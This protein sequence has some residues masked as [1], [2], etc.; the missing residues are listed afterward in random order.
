M[1]RDLRTCCLRELAFQIISTQY[2][3]PH[4]HHQSDQNDDE[5]FNDEYDDVED[6]FGQDLKGKAAYA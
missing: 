4:L 5:A 1:G 2:N 6:N 3:D